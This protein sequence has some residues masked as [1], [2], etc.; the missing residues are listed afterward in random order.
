MVL[1]TLGPG[2]YVGERSLIDNKPHSASVFAEVPTDA[3]ALG[4][5]EFA[6]CMPEGDSM[7]HAVLRGWCSGCVMRTARSSPWP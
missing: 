5:L 7:A 4:Q 6:R 3:L 2:D 1:A